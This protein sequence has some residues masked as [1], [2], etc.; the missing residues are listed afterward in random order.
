[1][2]SP[3]S[4]LQ[5]NADHTKLHARNQWEVKPI[6]YHLQKAG[7]TVPWHVDWLQS[8]QTG[9]TLP[10]YQQLHF[11]V[12]SLSG[13]ITSSRSSV[14]W[15]SLTWLLTC[16]Y[17]PFRNASKN[18]GL[19]WVSYGGTPLAHTSTIGYNQI[20]MFRPFK[21][22]QQIKSGETV[23]FTDME[24]TLRSRK[25]LQ[26]GSWLQIAVLSRYQK[27]GETIESCLKMNVSEWNVMNKFETQT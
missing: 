5:C 14:A 11:L 24:D 1:M 6:F 25:R 7:K 20:E 4:L 15:I 23:V 10:S 17:K 21:P 26:K 12:Y 27:A 13:R 22:K 16:C 9:L 8:V 18:L 19:I 3:T 2:S